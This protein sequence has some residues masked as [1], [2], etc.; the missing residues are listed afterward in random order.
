MNVLFLSN[1][2]GEDVITRHLVRAYQSVRPK[3][4]V[5][6]MSLVGTGRTFDEMPFVERFSVQWNPPSGGFIK[7]IS[8]VFFDLKAGMLRAHF[9]Q[10]REARQ[11]RYDLIVA[12][13]DLFPLFV[14][15]WLRAK[16]RVLI[17]TAKSDLFEPHFPVERWLLKRWANVVFT[18][19]QVTADSLVSTGVA[20]KYLGNVMMDDVTPISPHGAR[21]E[22]SRRGRDDNPLIVGILPG[23]RDEAYANFERIAEVMKGCPVDWRLRVAVPAQ[24]DRL[25]FP[26][27]AFQQEYSWVTFQEMLNEVDVVIGLA[28]T[29]NEQ[30]VGCGIPVIAFQGTGPQTTLRRF[31]QQQQLLRG[32]V[33]LVEGASSAIIASQIIKLTKDDQWFATVRKEGPVVMGPPGASQ[34]IVKELTCILGY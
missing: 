3:D 10:I 17:A 13:G 9:R 16:Q 4:N 24:L 21:P 2:H 6:I 18:R 12:V 34:H 26:Q 5:Y 27:S 15:R 14:S 20:A 30:C 33:R 8:S 11:H 7:S 32:G 19:D 22:R 1:G 29:A 25:R 28:G 23:S 31:R